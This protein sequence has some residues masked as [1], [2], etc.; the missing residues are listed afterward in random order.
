MA[1]S[2]TDVRHIAALARLG[3]PEGRIGA[4]VAELNGIL[5]HMEEL[6]KVKTREAVPVAG[7]AAG[8]MPLREDTGPPLPLA[9]A[10]DRFAPAVRD[11]FLLVPR[12]ATHTAAGAVADAGG[13][14]AE[15]PE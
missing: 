3:L 4:L 14:A 13:D 6:S 5:A 8:G 12:L 2:E 11:G 9:R 1:V 15:L 7:V 10:R